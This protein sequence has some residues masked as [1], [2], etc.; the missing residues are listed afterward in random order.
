[1]VLTPETDLFGE[2]AETIEA[3]EV[4]WQ[5]EFSASI[6]LLRSMA[7]EARESY[8][9]GHATPMHFAAD[10]RIVRDPLR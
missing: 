10:G 1:M 3:D 5:E 9:T 8:L 4:G 7:S 6:E 2:S